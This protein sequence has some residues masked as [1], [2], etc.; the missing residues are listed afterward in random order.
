MLWA[1]IDP[2]DHENTRLHELKSV[3]RLLQ[4]K[5]AGTY[6]RA[7]SEAVCAGTLSFVNAWELRDDYQNGPY[8]YEV[9]FPN[10]PNNNKIIHHMTR[11]SQ[12]A[13]MKWAKSKNIPSFRQY[14]QQTQQKSLQE[15]IANSSDI[16]LL[17][18]DE[19]NPAKML[20]LAAPS[21][22]DRTN[23][24]SPAELRAAHDAWH[25][26]TENGDPKASG[27]S[28]KESIMKFLNAH[29]EYKSFSR[30]AKLRISTVANYDKKGGAPKTP[31]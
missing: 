8:D 31:E 6:Q 28:V 27:A 23:P 9:T 11:V 16:E 13:F 21:Y 4:Y 29:D 15:N 22:L 10:L 30:E 12:A 3:L 25:A 26:V 2:M 1:A 17:A 19:I 7:I 18:D 20:A 14:I 5:K 24:L